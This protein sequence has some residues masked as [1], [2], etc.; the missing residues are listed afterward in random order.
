MPGSGGAWKRCS[1]VAWKR[2]SGVARKPGS[3]V[4]P[5]TRK[6][7]LRFIWFI[8]N[9]SYL[10]YRNLCAHEISLP[11][12]SVIRYD[13]TCYLLDTDPFFMAGHIDG[14]VSRADHRRYAPVAGSDP[15]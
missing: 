5:R 7:F 12:Y 10:R 15:I 13:D 2:C 4:A 3:V 9:I 8:G 1:G 6:N 14:G 11:P